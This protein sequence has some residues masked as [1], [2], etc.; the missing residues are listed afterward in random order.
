MLAQP[1]DSEE[2]TKSESKNEPKISDDPKINVEPKI[3]DDL[4]I[5]EEPKIKVEPIEVKSEVG[6]S[7]KI[8][9]K[10]ED[11]QADAQFSSDLKQITPDNPPIVISDGESVISISD[12]DSDDETVH[13]I[14]PNMPAGDADVSSTDSDIPQRRPRSKN[15]SRRAY[16][17][18]S[19]TEDSDEMADTKPKTD[20]FL[21]GSD[22]SAD[23]EPAESDL[24][25]VS[26]VPNISNEENHL[27]LLQRLND[28]DDLKFLSK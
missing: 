8:E 26:N 16:L 23:E 3:S 14:D 20:K 11:N 1:D 19:D 27:A 25:F 10:S 24:E 28:L 21:V 5:K 12:S 4:K 17:F 9:P 2:M 15:Y 18:Q 13:A 22:R 7:I 6:E